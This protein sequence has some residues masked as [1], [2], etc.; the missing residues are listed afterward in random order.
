MA[1]DFRLIAL[2]I[3]RILNTEDPAK[4]KPPGGGRT[5]GRHCNSDALMPWGAERGARRWSYELKDRKIPD[6][7]TTEAMGRRDGLASIPMPFVSWPNHLLWP[8]RGDS[9]PAFEFPSSRPYKLGFLAG[10]FCKPLIYMVGDT[11]IEPV[12]PAV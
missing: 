4:K 12:T 8:A 6:T 9:F 3:W 10:I 1:P 11:G 2:A 5:T 7:F